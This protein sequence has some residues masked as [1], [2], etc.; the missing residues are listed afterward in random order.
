[1][2]S[3]SGARLTEMLAE[4]GKRVL[5]WLIVLVGFFAWWMSMLLLF[6]LVLVNT[7]H[8]S[9]Q[10]ILQLSAGLTLLSGIAYA[11]VMVLRAK[12]SAS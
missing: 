5:Q 10:T 11:A 9:F 12:R 8:I 3:K 1:M 2:T 7:W 4:G 6:S